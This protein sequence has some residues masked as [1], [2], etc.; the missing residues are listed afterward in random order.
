MMLRNKL[1]RRVEV[2]TW[3]F[4]DKE[5]SAADRYELENHLASSAEARRLFGE[6]VDMHNSLNEFFAER[7]PVVADAIAA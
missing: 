3:M 7:R 4:L 2:L 5:I 6:L 1:R